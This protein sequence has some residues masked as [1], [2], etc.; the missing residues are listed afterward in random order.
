MKRLSDRAVESSCHFGRDEIYRMIY[1][2]LGTLY[3]RIRDGDAA[4]DVAGAHEAV[5]P[6][7]CQPVSTA[8][9]HGRGAGDW[10]AAAALGDLG[11]GEL[12]RCVPRPLESGVHRQD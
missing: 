6:A 1:N 12:P 2:L 10:K 4:G 11:G 9:A 5:C 7:D 8:A 3:I